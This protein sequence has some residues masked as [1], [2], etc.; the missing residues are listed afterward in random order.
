MNISKYQEALVECQKALEVNSYLSAAKSRIG[1][2]YIQLHNPQKGIPYVQAVLR[3]D[4]EDGQAHADLARGFELL[5]D[6][7][8]AVTEYRRALTLDPSLNRIRY[9]LGRLYRRQGK[10]ELAENEFRVFERNEAVERAKRASGLS[11]SKD[12]PVDDTDGPAH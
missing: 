8:K 9:I 10:A 3:E 12:S 5:G 7:D 4:P 11:Q 1:R 2:I 6:L